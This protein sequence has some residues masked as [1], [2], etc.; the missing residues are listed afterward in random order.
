LKSPK[1]SSLAIK[2]FFSFI[3]IAGPAKIGKKHRKN[4]VARFPDLHSKI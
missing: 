2:N 3:L 4:V 1:T